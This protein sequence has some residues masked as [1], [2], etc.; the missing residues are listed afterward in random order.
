MKIN[1]L[2][3]K[4]SDT[5]IN[6]LIKQGISFF[7]VSGIGWCI[8]FSTYLIL[9]YFFGIPISYANMLSSI[10]AVTYV[11]LMSTRNI[12][13]NEMSK[14]SLKY[15]YIIYFTYEVILVLIISF[16]AQWLFNIIS[17]TDLIEISIIG[18]YLKIIIKILITP[19]TMVI[20]FIVM[21]NLIEKL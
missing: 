1:K 11:F 5:K 15:K 10:P 18:N 19:I 12:F 14:I 17:K 3:F 16:F 7:I 21:K 8:D 13:K 9:T 2:Q 20:N 4:E 6:R